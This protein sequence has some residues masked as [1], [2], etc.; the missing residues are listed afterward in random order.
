MRAGMETPTGQGAPGTPGAAG[1]GPV[2]GTMLLATGAGGGGTDSYGGVPGARTE[3]EGGAERLQVAFA[4]IPPQALQQIC[5]W[6]VGGQAVALSTT[7]TKPVPVSRNAAV[8]LRVLDLMENQLGPEAAEMLCVALETS[9]VE[10]VRL[11]FNDIGRPGADGLASVVTVSPR[12]RALDV[13]GNSLTGADMRKLLKAISF[14]TTIT[15]VDLGFNQLGPE[16]AQVLANALERNAS[17]TSLDVCSNEIGPDGALKLATLLSL[18]TCGLRILEVSA[19]RIGARGAEALFEGAKHA[20]SVLERLSCSSNSIGNAPSALKTLGEL[21]LVHRS[22][23]QLDLRHN[24]IPGALIA[25]L[26]DGLASC[27]RL[28]FVSFAGNPIGREGVTTKLV[29][30][31]ALSE[32]LMGL[33]VSSCGLESPG[34]VQFAALVSQS[35][36]ITDLNM[37][38]NNI[39]DGGAD[40]MAK[41][42]RHARRLVSLDLSMNLISIGGA[43]MLLEA[44]QHAPKLTGMALHGNSIG[45]SMQLKLDAVL[46]RRRP[47]DYVRASNAMPPHRKPAALPLE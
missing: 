3:I 45:R 2:S 18:P 13:R 12:L 42:L 44:A 15:T 23:T 17:V 40:A 27:A 6:L 21:L 47:E 30:S 22:L 35:R 38:N 24:G 8:A 9:L 25:G 26:A 5:A 32:T 20:Q 31:L 33:D 46:L 19:N 29:Q 1:G 28:A 7:G 4:P 11:R 16:G 37:S 14:S 34:C 41:V 10:E 43:A 36:T 39:D